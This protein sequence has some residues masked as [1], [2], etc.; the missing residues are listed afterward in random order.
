MKQNAGVSPMDQWAPDFIDF[1]ACLNAR[2]VDVVLVGGYA[3]ALHGFVRATGDI[4]FL[5]RRTQ[6]NVTRLRQALMDFGAPPEVLDEEALMSPDIVTQFGVPPF[7]IDLLNQIDGVPVED[8]WKGAVERVFATQTLRVIG[9]AELL[10]N[11]A[12]TGRPKDQEDLRQLKAIA[13]K[14]G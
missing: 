13:S 10:R 6:R 8:V 12:S 3:V 2:K 11:K 9:L 7:R 1:V 14:K 5:Y 4:D